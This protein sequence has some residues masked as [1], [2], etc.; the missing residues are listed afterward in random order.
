MYYTAKLHVAFGK[1]L[2]MG[3]ESDCL[4]SSMDFIFPVDKSWILIMSMDVCSANSKH[5]KK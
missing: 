5:T 2:T 3:N 4:S 1:P